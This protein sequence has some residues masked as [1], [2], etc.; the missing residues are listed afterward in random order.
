MVGYERISVR[1]TYVKQDDG[2]REVFVEKEGGPSR[3]DL[4]GQYHDDGEGGAHLGK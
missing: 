2:Y 3:W 1:E 4:I